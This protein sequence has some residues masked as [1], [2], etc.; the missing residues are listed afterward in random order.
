VLPGLTYIVE[1]RLD[2][3]SVDQELFSSLAES[4]MD[5]GEE[6]EGFGREDV[7][8]AL[9]DR[10]GEV[11]ASGEGHFSCSAFAVCVVAFH[12]ELSRR[13]NRIEACIYGM[14]ERVMI[15]K[16]QRS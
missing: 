14:K 12:K 4:S 8:R 3:L 9:G 6:R 16:R 13:N 10:G 2:L 15:R 5:D 11:D 1:F 7:L